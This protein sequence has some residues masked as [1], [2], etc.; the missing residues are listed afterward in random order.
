MRNIAIEVPTQTQP[1]LQ[2]T[3]HPFRASNVNPT[4]A[5]DK[6]ASN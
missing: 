3:F 5:V 6:S 1:S 2:R 4:R